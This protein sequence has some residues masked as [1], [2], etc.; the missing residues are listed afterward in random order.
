MSDPGPHGPLFCN[1]YKV[2]VLKVLT[3][4]VNQK[5]LQTELTLIRLPL[6]K[7]SDQGLPVSDSDKHFGEF[8]P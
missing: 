2:D 4:V 3:L 7:Q 8:Q 6:L 1:I 5:V